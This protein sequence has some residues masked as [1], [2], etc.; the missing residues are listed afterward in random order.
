MYVNAQGVYVRV[1]GVC[2]AALTASGCGTQ[3]P[4][5]SSTQEL[6][7]VSENIPSGYDRWDELDGGP[8]GIPEMDDLAR[9]YG[10]EQ[11]SL[12]TESHLK[13]Y[14]GVAQLEDYCV[15]GFHSP[16]EAQESGL[17]D[18]AILSR[19]NEAYTIVLPALP[20]ENVRMMLDKYR[21]FCSGEV[22][23][24]DIQTDTP[25]ENT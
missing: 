2:V 15:V 14:M 11:I 8:S 13:D 3:S 5:T 17:M 21:P 10:L 6:P 12:P 25:V 7:A 20:P 24:D 1:I 16:E 19:L 4:E 18:V 23:F 9:A 22:E